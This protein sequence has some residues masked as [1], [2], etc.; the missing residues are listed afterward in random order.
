MEKTVKTSSK[1]WL[2]EALNEYT[3]KKE[4]IL[5]DDK[6]IKIKEDDLNSAVNLIK[7]AKAKEGKSSTQ[8]TKSLTSIGLSSAGICVIMLAIA[9][10]EPT[11]KL[12]LLLVGGIVLAI[13]GGYDALRAL[14]I[15]YEVKN[16]DNNDLTFH[17]KPKAKY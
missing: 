9:D 11:T 13:S 15:K 1:N 3:S 12:S 16:K 4:F 10:P 2:E 5:V 6:E 17:V 8:I 7:A 14:Q